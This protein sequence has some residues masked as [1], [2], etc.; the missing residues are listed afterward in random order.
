MIPLDE[1]PPVLV[2]LLVG[3]VWLVVG[4]GSGWAGHRLPTRRL[5]HDTWLTAPRS[6]ERGGRWY[7]RALRIRR[8]KDRLPEAGAFF[9][10]GSSKARL[11]DRST[12]GL[13]RF[14]VETRRAEYVHWANACAGPLFFVFRPYWLGI[15]MTG[16]G[17]VV[18][19]PFVAVQR[20]NRA[21]LTRTLDR[22]TRRGAST[23][24]R[25]PGG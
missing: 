9:R 1:L 21:R 6:F 13:E 12:E 17:L 16:F 19:L 10:G 8:W 23:V 4:I 18:H 25:P 5:D 24:E 14:V 2:V 3:L 7:E 15:A 11:T 20:Y 22:R